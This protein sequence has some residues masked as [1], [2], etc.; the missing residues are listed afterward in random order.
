MLVVLIPICYAMSL[1]VPMIGA[2]PM[3]FASF[4]IPTLKILLHKLYHRIWVNFSDFRYDIFA[5][6]FACGRFD[7]QNQA[8]LKSRGS[9]VKVSAMC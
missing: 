3:D 4:T 9:S 6:D 8:L 7:H 2:I 1:D 5:A